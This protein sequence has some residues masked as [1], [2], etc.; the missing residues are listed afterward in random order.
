MVASAFWQSAERALG[1]MLF[2][3]P[4]TGNPWISGQFLRLLSTLEK[5]NEVAS[6]SNGLV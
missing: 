2:S 4:N 3:E 1:Q 5:V 6:F